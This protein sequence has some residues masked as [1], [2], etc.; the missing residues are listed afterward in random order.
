M[1]R[2][3]QRDPQ[4]ALLQVAEH[5][6]EEEAHDGDEAHEL[7]VLVVGL[8][9]H[10]AREH[11]QDGPGGEGLDKGDQVFRSAVEKVVAEQRRQRRGQRHPDP[12]TKDVGC[13]APSTLH[14]GGRGQ[15]FRDVGEEDGGDEGG[16]DAAASEE[17]DPDGR[18]LGD[19]VQERAY[20]CPR[21]ALFVPGF[22][23]RP[24]PLLFT[25]LSARKKATA[26]SNSPR[27][28][29]SKPPIS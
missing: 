22:L 12:E 10:G 21:V 1:A 18:R 28:E 3:V 4:I 7:A 14:A 24:P 19:A 2:N 13:G 25:S 5:E 6:G 11:R 8:W 20:G 23:R 27:D 16:A 15:S 26:P 9:H 29:E 17:A